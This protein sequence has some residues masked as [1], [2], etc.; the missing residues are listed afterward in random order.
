MSADFNDTRPVR[1]RKPHRCVECARTIE[2][3]EVYYRTA[4][5]WEG[6]FFTVKTCAHCHIARH[7]FWSRPGSGWL[8]WTYEGQFAAGE[9]EEFLLDRRLQDPA[10][11]AFGWRLIVGHRRQWRRKDGSLWALPAHETLAKGER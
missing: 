11:Q 7:W 8:E 3:G 4:A 1:A 6:D 10:E 9:W 5:K 2:P